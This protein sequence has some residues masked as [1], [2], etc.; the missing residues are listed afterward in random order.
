MMTNNRILPYDRYEKYGVKALS[1]VEL[2]AVILRNGTRDM[3]VLELASSILNIAGQDNRILG[4]QNLTYEELITI[5][6]IGRVKAISIEC[7]VELSKRMAM[8]KR[9]STLRFCDSKTIARYYMEQLRHLQYETV[10]LVL[11]DN[12]NNLIKDLT[13][14]TG[15]VNS[16]TISTRDIFLN[17]FR[18]RASGIFIIHNHPSGDPTPSKQDI[19]ITR[20][21]REGGNFMDIPLIDHI[22]I[23][24]NVYV[25]LKEDGLL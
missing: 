16:S 9:K 12:K 13:L 10:L 21:I 19:L 4:L 7:V 15:S 22:V 2:L 1:D 8:Q 6:G 25:S 14:S 18:Y 3:D 17:A 11:V 23:G 20:K 5:K 24:D